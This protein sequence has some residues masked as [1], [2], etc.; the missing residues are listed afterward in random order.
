M[1]DL[2]AAVA[3]CLGLFG[4]GS[5]HVAR[6]VDRSALDIVHFD[7]P[8]FGLGV[9]NALDVAAELFPFGKHLV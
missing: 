6:E 1:N 3:F 7:P 9:Q 4:D 5:H 2:G 8:G